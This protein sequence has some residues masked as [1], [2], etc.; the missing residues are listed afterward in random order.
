ME[1]KLYCFNKGIK[2]HNELKNKNLH[3]NFL[4]LL[5]GADSLMGAVKD[6][7]ISHGG[8]PPH[9]IESIND[10]SYELTLAIAG[11]TEQDISIMQIGNKLNIASK[12]NAEEK[13][14][15][16][17][18]KGIAERDFNKDFILGDYI[19]VGEANIENG[20]LSIHLKKNVPEEMK[21][22]KILISN[23]SNNENEDQ[24]AT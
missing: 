17:I 1:I 16:F 10:N 12:R 3:Q 19:E 5:I 23:S 6:S 15:K 9:N 22:R 21:P 8:F 24:I 14:R 13:E 4:A 20:I 11:F 7:K 2:M 18:Y